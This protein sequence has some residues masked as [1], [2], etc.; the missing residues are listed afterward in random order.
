MGQEKLVE[1]KNLLSHPF[2][3]M[4]KIM[5]LAILALTFPFTPIP[6]DDGSHNCIREWWNVDAFIRTNDTNK[7][8]SIT[9]SFEYE[10]ETPA[11]NL[12]F[13]L[14][15][16]DEKRMYDLGCYNAPINELKHSKDSLNLS[17]KKSWMKGEYPHYTIHLENKGVIVEMYIEAEGEPHFVAEDAGGILPVGLGYYRYLFIPRCKAWG[18]LQLEGKKEEFTGVAY[19]EH[20]WGNWSYNNPLRNA[21]FETILGYAKLLKWWWKNKSISFNSITISSDNPFSYDWAWANFDNGWNIFYGAIPFWL[22]EIPFCILYLFDGEKTI[23]FG[24]I[25]YEY[26]DGIFVEGTYIPT[27]IKVVAEGE[28]KLNL[29]MEMNNTPHIYTSNLTS[30]YWKK[31][32]LYECP[33]KIYGWYDNGE[34]INLTGKCEI[35]IE[36]QVSLLEYFMVKIAFYIKPFGIDYIFFSYLF[37]IIFSLQFRLFPFYLSFYISHIRY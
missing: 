35:E 1:V 20:V 22:N 36:R 8:Y 26:I 3:F 34:K 21:S 23:E 18:W 15:N 37:N 31:L 27:K 32:I 13:T 24:K 4:Q 19:Y 12:F 25:S 30:F 11:S 10:K 17:F 6:S 2:L 14:F 28:G 5:V 29:F 16:L 33:G 7:N 9:A